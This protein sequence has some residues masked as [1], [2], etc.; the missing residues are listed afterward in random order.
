MTDYSK[1]AIQLRNQIHM[2]P[3]IGYD[4]PRTLELIRKELTK[5]GIPYTERFGKSS[6]V[7]TINPEKT[8]FTI[9]IRADMDALPI[10]EHS[11]RPYASRIP[12]AMHACG[13]D[14]HTS[15]LL[16]VAHKLQDMRDQISCRVK[17][18][19]TPAEEFAPSGCQLMAED[20]VMDDIDCIVACHVDPLFS[21]G[22]VAID[23]G[24][25][26]GNSLGFSIEMFG[27]NSHAAFQH[28]GKDAISM[29]VQ[30]YTALELMIAKE[31]DPAEPCLLNIGAFNGGYTNNVICDYC[32]LYGTLRTQSDETNDYLIK[33]IKE[34]AGGVAAMNGG[35]YQ[36]SIA[37]FLPYVIND[38]FITSRMYAS[39]E[40]TLGVGNIYHK[41]RTLTGEDFSFLCRKKPGMMFRLGT[42]GGPQT[43]YS[44]HT[45][46][47]DVDERCFDTGLSL[48]V[49][50]V[51]DNMDG[52]AAVR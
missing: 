9:G 41:K 38:A 18:L 5:L 44:I 37:K 15:I 42:C 33:R 7:A 52:F 3:E 36:F 21:A 32:K 40:K 48:F 10:Q 26:G 28:K 39:A 2:Y 31:V 23:E 19:F 16:G 51:L 13:H 12:G 47:F 1:Y 22:S 17:L 11:T 4:L 8:G 45:D 24:G 46:R 49:Q 29:A 27:Q 43:T 30:V 6:I 35:R 25:Q 14:V 20:G 34:I 50:F